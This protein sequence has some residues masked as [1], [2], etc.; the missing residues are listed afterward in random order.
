MG[1]FDLDCVQMYLVRYAEL[2]VYV[3]A[4]ILG[5]IADLRMIIAGYSFLRIIL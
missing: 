4:F 2:R 5:K 3:F 1:T